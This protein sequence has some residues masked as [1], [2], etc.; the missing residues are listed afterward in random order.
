ML[1]LIYYMIRGTKFGLQTGG[2]V[3]GILNVITTFSKMEI[4]WK[5]NQL[6]KWIK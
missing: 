6:L 2:N 4:K 3:E 5:K 1:N